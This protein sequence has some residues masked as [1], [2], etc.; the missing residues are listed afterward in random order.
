MT[1]GIAA[2]D[3]AQSGDGNVGT[4]HGFEHRCARWRD[5]I[6]TDQ[7]TRRLGDVR[8]GDAAV[9][10]PDR[11]LPVRPLF[12]ELRGRRQGA[13]PGAVGLRRRRRR[14]PD[15][16]RIA[17]ARRGRR[18]QRPAQAVAGDLRRH[19]CRRHGDAV[20]RDPRAQGRQSVARHG[21]VRGG[22]RGCGIRGRVLQRDDADAG[23]AR[24]DRQIVRHRLGD[25]LRRRPRRPR[26]HGG[27]HRHRPD[28]RQDHA[29]LLTRLEPQCRHAR[30]RSAGRPVLG[31][32][33]AYLLSPAVPVHAGRAPS[34]GAWHCA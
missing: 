8:M 15:R 29:R 33:V 3:A 21:R 5:A 9:L 27:L 20:A 4:N 13:W 12:R 25:G 2:G 34:R 16:G 17:A 31:A 6:G 11:H 24:Q 14:H 1:V 18:R 7:S 32:F 26:F 22:E 19:S 23:A 10:Y 28:H 30:E